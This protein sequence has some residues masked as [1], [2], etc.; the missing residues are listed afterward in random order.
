MRERK[1]ET[2]R[3]RQTEIERQTDRQRQRETDKLTE[4]NCTII[5]FQGEHFLCVLRIGKR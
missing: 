5:K 2:E 4:G 1:R 3:D